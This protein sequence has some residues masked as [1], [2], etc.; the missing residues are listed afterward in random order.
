MSK[1]NNSKPHNM[2]NKIQNIKK[3]Q[4]GI[5][6]AAGVFSRGEGCLLGGGGWLAEKQRKWRL[7][8][9]TLIIAHGSQT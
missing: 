2:K 9:A 5:Y 1:N 8:K 6:G 4:N 3:N 7:F